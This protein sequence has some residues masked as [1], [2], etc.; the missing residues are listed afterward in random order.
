MKIVWSPFA[1]ERVE[2]IAQYI[3]QD[4]PEA[5]I[6]WV[7]RL[8]ETVERLQHYPES[9]R[10]LPEVDSPRLREVIFGAYRIIYSVKDQVDILTVRR[11][12]QLLQ[13]NELDELD[14]NRQ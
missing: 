9:G 2:D 13:M 3:A 10:R 12:S 1:L 4:K 5:A 11:G 8:F 14:D 6:K 7:N